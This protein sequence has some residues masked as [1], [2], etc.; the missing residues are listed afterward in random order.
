MLSKKEQVTEKCIQYLSMYVK[1]KMDKRS[2][3]LFRDKFQGG[4]NYFFKARE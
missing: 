3:I 4:K 2:N 1:L